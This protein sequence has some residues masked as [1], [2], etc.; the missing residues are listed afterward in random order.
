MLRA[1][2]S[3]SWQV[4]TTAN[5]KVVVTMSW[6]RNANGNGPPDTPLEC[7]IST[8]ESLGP[9]VSGVVANLKLSGYE[10][11]GPIA[12]D[13]INPPPIPA[14]SKPHVEVYH[15]TS[16]D[17]YKKLVEA[18]RAERGDTARLSP[19]DPS[20][21]AYAAIAELPWEVRYTTR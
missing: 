19:N 15:W 17:D 21:S 18:R 16:V 9:Y 7:T 1:D 2:G 14:D 20:L 6:F 13:S 10:V 4:P 3:V 8:P 12:R 11:L 5:S